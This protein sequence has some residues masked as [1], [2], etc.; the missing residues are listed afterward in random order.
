[1][2]RELFREY[3]R[4]LG[5]DLCFQDFA[6]ELEQLPGDYAPPDGWL[7]LVTS[8][9]EPI[10]CAGIRKIAHGVCELKRMY[11]RPDF[12]GLKLGR[13]L[14]QQLIAEARRIGY[15]KMRLDTIGTMVEA[16]RLYRSLGFREIKPYYNNPIPGAMFMELDL[17]PQMDLDGN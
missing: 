2:T 16:I 12:R 9:R 8:A 14:A 4:S 5:F 1:M 3:E 11:V 15:T 13:R 7:L 6:R 17:L 10:G